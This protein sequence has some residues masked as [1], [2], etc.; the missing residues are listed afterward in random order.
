VS[1]PRNV[2]TYRSESHRSERYPCVHDQGSSA[3]EGEFG[4]ALSL[5][6]DGIV[7]AKACGRDNHGN[8]RNNPIFSR[9]VR[10]VKQD[11]SQHPFSGVR[12]ELEPFATPIVGVRAMGRIH[13][14][15]S[16][17]CG[18]CD[19][20]QDLFGCLTTSTTLKTRSYGLRHFLVRTVMYSCS[21]YRQ[22]Q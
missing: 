20:S 10:Q 16:R 8:L 12:V 17:V 22:L 2:G 11:L 1:H 3:F 4:K 13:N 5:S 14:T 19:L 9:C 15:P 21:A 18:Q 7:W 6:V